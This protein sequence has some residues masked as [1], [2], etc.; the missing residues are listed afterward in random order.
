[1]QSQIDE[2]YEKI[3]AHI[4]K[5]PLLYSEPLSQLLQAK[6]YLKCEN[7]QITGSFKLRGALNKV[8]SLTKEQRERGIICA[9]TGN[10][11]AAVAYA[12]QL[13]KIPATIFVP[14]DASEAKLENI[15]RYKAKIQTVMGDCG[16]AEEHGRRA[17]SEQNL[18]YISPYNDEQIIAGQGTIAREI[19]DDLDNVDAILVATGGGGLIAGISQY[20]VKRLNRPQIIG[21]LPKNAPVF[22]D[23]IAGNHA[24]VELNQP[25]LSDA[26]A[27]GMET[28]SLT[29]D[30]CRESVDDYIQVSEDSIMQ[31]MQF[32]LT[33]HHMVV[34]GAGALPLAA[35][36]KQPSLWR[37]KTIILVLSGGNVNKSILQSILV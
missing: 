37:D 4:I 23:S 2:A 34:E 22:W 29:L 5:T 14:Q 19:C 31:A 3:Q 33:Q 30:L 28:D 36:M 24:A 18:V 6:V 17:A 9:S 10:H 26:T 7:L 27:G 12:C 25:T 13:L 16:V 20:F 32:I 11:G 21:C 15:A 35:A 1:M 8:L